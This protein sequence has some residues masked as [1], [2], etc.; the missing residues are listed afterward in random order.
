MAA[1]DGCKDCTEAGKSLRP[2]CTK[3]DI[4]KV[5][6]PRDPNNCLQSDFWGPIKYLNESSYMSWYLLIDFRNGL[7]R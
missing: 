3:G 2:M 7:R 1:A 4:G 6:E 5:Y